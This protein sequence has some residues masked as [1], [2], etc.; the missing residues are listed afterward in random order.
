MRVFFVFKFESEDGCR[1]ER[2]WLMLTDS[3]ENT[4]KGLL[5][6]QPVY[7]KDVMLGEEVTFSKAQIAAVM[8][9]QQFDESK[10][11]VITS[12]ALESEQVNWVLKS[13]ELNFDSDSGWQ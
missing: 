13:D 6:N 8:V 3:S 1:A 7:L 9:E 12:K 11:A 2:M 10:L 5:T 4:Y